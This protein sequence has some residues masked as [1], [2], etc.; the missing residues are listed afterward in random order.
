[1]TSDKVLI[2][3]S[4]VAYYPVRVS[5]GGLNVLF[6]CCQKHDCL[7]LG[8]TFLIFRKMPTKSGED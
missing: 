2:M 1:M 6:V 8:F 3:P 5:A 7:P 4:I